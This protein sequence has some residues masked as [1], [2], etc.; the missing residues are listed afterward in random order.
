MSQVERLLEEYRYHLTRPQRTT[1]AAPE[2]VWFAVHD[3]SAERR[4]LMRLDLFAQATKSAGW[5]WR[6][7]DLANRFGAWMADHEYKDAYFDAPDLAGGLIH[8]FAE[9]LIR[10]LGNEL[11]SLSLGDQSILAL[12]GASSLFGLMK[13]ATLVSGIESMIPGRL[14]VF[15]PGHFD[16]ERGQYRFLDARDGWNYHA[17]PITG[18]KG[19]VSP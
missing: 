3:P 8:D 7:I 4:I 11:R 9:D 2:R 18:A 14:L 15:F 10:D 12:T 1:L 6:H 5:H 13:I 17:L 16:E 19:T